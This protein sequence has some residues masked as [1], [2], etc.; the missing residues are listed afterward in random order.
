MLTATV[1][2]V[3]VTALILRRSRAPGRDA[4]RVLDTAL[5]LR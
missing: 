4:T 1:L 5:G 2:A 3:A